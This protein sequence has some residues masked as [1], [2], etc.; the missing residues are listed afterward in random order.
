MKASETIT[1]L[2]SEGKQLPENYR[3]EQATV[4]IEANRIGKATLHLYAGRT[5]EEPFEFSDNDTFRHGNCIRIDVIR[6]NRT[7]TLFEGLVISTELRSGFDGPDMLVVECRHYAYLTTMGR[8]NGVFEE[9]KDSDIF[10]KIISGYPEIKLKTEDTPVV[11][12]SLVQYYSTDWDFILSR[13]DACGLIVTTSGKEIDIRKPDVAA[14][15]IA[16]Y[17]YRVNVSDF[18]GSLSLSSQYGEVCATGWSYSQQELLQEQAEKQET[19]KQGDLRVEDLSKLNPNKLLFQTDA[20]P[21]KE[22]LKG[23]A[24]AMSVKS[25][26]S[27]YKGSFT[28]EG[29]GSVV[30][31]SVVSLKGFGKRFDGNVW[32]GSVEHTIKTRSW[33][34][35]IGMGL[36]EYKVVEQPDIVAPLAS[37]L[38]PGIRGL[39]I[40]I[41]RKL[42][43]DPAEEERILVELPLLNGDNSQVWAR[44]ATP[45]SG[46]RTGILFVPEVGDE[47]V[48][49]FFN[50]DPC[51]PVILGSMFGSKMAPPVPLSEKNGI[52]TILTKEKLKLEFDDEKKI[53][54]VG[55]PGGALIEVNDD[56]KSITLNDQNKNS[57][58]LDSNGI[59]IRS[60]KDIILKAQGNIDVQSTSN[61]TIKAQSNLTLEGMNVEGK[62]KVGIKM[63]GNASA[64][65]SASGNTTVK[66]SIIMIN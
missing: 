59:T 55:T 54:T 11:H 53:I 22:L 21:E 7:T 33:K 23:W 39:H 30:P 4:R 40:G 8:K 36:P 43:E 29:E 1:I 44:L 50:N 45:Y 52:K 26:L 37:G 28:V 63:K 42:H 12:A 3:L 46:N 2:Y 17:T 13:A 19:N 41:V 49:G 27:R 58:I 65:L 31:G 57:I 47:V 62:A 25:A 61:A 51:Y 35:R 32:V 18:E 60:N 56:Q 66:G 20:S 64:E 9:N 6:E 38:L 15:A 14:E 34:C 5:E 16:E 24:N 48:V 10:K